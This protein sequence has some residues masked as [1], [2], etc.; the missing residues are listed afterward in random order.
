MK[1]RKGGGIHLVLR[2]KLDEYLVFVVGGQDGRDLAARI[3]RGKGVFNL[4]GGD[5]NYRC[6]VSVDL[7]IDLG[8]L[9]CKSLDTS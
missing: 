7:D 9:I 3:S 5:S 8:V 4:L 2:R 6:L 1:E